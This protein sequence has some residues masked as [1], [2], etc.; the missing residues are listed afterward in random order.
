MELFA[1]LQVKFE[2]LLSFWFLELKV[3]ILKHLEEGNK[4]KFF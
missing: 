2:K 4:Y 1:L 3:K